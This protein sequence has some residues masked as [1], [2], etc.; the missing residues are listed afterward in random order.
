MKGQVLDDPTQSE[1][2]PPRP[3][4]SPTQRFWKR[5]SIP[6]T[7]ASPTRSAQELLAACSKPDPDDPEQPGPVTAKYI[8]VAGPPSPESS[9]RILGG[10][11]GRPEPP[12]LSR[13]CERGVFVRGSSKLPMTSAFPSLSRSRLSKESAKEPL[14]ISGVPFHFIPRRTHRASPSI[15]PPWG[16][17]EN[18][19]CRI[20]N[21]H[22]LDGRAEVE[23]ESRS[24]R[25]RIISFD[26]SRSLSVTEVRHEKGREIPRIGAEVAGLNARAGR[27]VPPCRRGA[28]RGPPSV[29][30]IV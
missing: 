18:W 20:I 25:D 15:F 11:P 5:T 30:H 27:G 24:S 14:P 23:L 21:D 3:S 17:P 7:F 26:F 4:F 13:A 9:I 16:W 29:P 1:G 19:M 2:E 12:L 10:Y 28:A 8:T 22:S 6:F